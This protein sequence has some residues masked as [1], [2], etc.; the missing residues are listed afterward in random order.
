VRLLP[1]MFSLLALGVAV[2][3]TTISPA[4]SPPPP[5]RETSPS[6][7]RFFVLLSEGVEITDAWSRRVFPW[8]GDRG[9]ELESLTVPRPSQASRQWRTGDASRRDRYPL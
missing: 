5:A 8:D 2:Y 3:G 1:L 6:A 7:V 9:V 4:D